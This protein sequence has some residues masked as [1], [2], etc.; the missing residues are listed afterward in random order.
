MRCHDSRSIHL[1]MVGLALFCVL[2]ANE[3]HA[4][5]FPEGGVRQCSSGACV[6]TQTCNTY[7]SECV[8]SRA[9]TQSCSV[10]GRTGVMA[11]DTAGNLLSGSCS[12]YSA[13]VCNNCDDDGD[14]SVDERLIAGSCDPRATAARVR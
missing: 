7:W 2:S 1:G 5:C 4:V 14:G 12:A 3:V 8:F 6:G 13:E 11:C 9:S 10:C